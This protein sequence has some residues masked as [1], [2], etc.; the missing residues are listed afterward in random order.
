MSLCRCVVLPLCPC[1]SD[2]AELT[3]PSRLVCPLSRFHSVRSSLNSQAP[4]LG[5]MGAGWVL[6]S[7]S[8]PQQSPVRRGRACVHSSTVPLQGDRVGGGRGKAEGEGGCR[9]DITR[10]DIAPAFAES[11][12][13]VD[14]VRIACKGLIPPTN[15]Y[16]SRSSLLPDVA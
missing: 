14:I 9:G 2:I 16:I 10:V 7:I 8:P 1:A 11:R 13:E 5:E 3:L 15:I 12:E 4:E 6:S